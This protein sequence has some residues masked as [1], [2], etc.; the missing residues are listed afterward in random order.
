ML[1]F[2]RTNP[3]LAA[4]SQLEGDLLTAALSLESVVS[5]GSVKSELVEVLGRVSLVEPDDVGGMEFRFGRP[6]LLDT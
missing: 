1:E 2:I 3:L 4:L 6:L 5:I